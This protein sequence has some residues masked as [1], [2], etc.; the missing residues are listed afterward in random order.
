MKI[1]DAYS[2]NY[3]FENFKIESTVGDYVNGIIIGLDE[4]NYYR[5]FVLDTS[6]DVKHVPS[7]CKFKIRNY[8]Y[9]SK[10]KHLCTI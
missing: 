4:E 2:Y 9:K 10:S 6:I 3:I 8:I 1:G 7:N 5:K